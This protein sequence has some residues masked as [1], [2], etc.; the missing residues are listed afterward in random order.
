MRM[1]IKV[2]QGRQLSGPVPAPSDIVSK[3][4]ERQLPAP[5]GMNIDTKGE[6]LTEFGR[7]R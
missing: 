6:K 5:L 2:A 7:F 1:S 3:V 4:Q